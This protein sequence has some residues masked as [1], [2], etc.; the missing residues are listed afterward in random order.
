[1]K[2]TREHDAIM[3]LLK[4][5]KYLSVLIDHFGVRENRNLVLKYC[6]S[7]VRARNDL[8]SWTPMIYS[9]SK[10]V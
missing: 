10:I 9:G 1:M 7:T 8:G 2:Y 4:L 6:T 5:E 3:A